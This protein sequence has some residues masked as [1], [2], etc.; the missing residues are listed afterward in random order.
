[1]RGAIADTEQ[2]LKVLKRLQ[3]IAPQLHPDDNQIEVAQLLKLRE[4]RY[5]RPRRHSLERL[6]GVRGDFCQRRVESRKPHNTDRLVETRDSA[7][8]EHDDRRA[9]AGLA[10]APTRLV[11]V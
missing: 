5:R 1:M 3:V 10:H 4:A 11:Y 2:P 7:S 6:R 9:K 8:P